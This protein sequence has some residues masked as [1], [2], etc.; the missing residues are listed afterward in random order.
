MAYLLDT[1]VI[2]NVVKFPD[3]NAASKLMEFREA[4]I[5]TSVLVSAE[6]R[7][8]YTKDNAAKRASFI[9]SLLASIPIEPWQAPYDWT[10]AELRTGLERRGEAIGQIDLLIAAQARAMD[11]V[12]VTDNEREFSRGPGLKIEN[13]LR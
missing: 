10:Y 13:W 7:F 11:A 9:E 3:G 4:G 6:L 5:F 8:G 2:S 1:N 12:L